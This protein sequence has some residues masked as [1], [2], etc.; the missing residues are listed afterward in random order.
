V[1]EKR[2]DFNA[3]VGTEPS[4]YAFLRVLTNLKKVKH[5]RPKGFFGGRQKGDNINHQKKRKR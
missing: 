1:K 5:P 3:G 2:E 4:K